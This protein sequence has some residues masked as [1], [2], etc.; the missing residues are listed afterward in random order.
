M[1]TPLVHG[2]SAD[3]LA[4]PGSGLA[5][6]VVDAHPVIQSTPFE[7]IAQIV[8]ADAEASSSVFRMPDLYN[9]YPEVVRSLDTTYVERGDVTLYYWDSVPRW[10]YE[11]FTWDQV[12]G[13]EPI[14]KTT[15]RIQQMELEKTAQEIWDLLKLYDVDACP[16]EVLPY[17]AA[18][19]G[20]P[21]PSAREESQR[22]F[23][24]ELAQTYRN[25][26]T[27]LSF[28]RLFESLGFE[29]TLQENYQRK[30]DGALVTGP[31]HALTSTDVVLSE[32][33]GTTTAST[34]PYSFQL[35]NTP[36]VRGSVKIKANSQSA[37]DPEIIIDD[38]EGGWPPGYTGVI[39]YV[40]G[41]GWITLAA[42]PT[43]V[44]QTI[45]VDYR[46]LVDPFPDPHGRRWTNLWRSSIVYVGLE[47]IDASVQLT[48]ELNNR[49]L[50]YL[51]LLKPAHV[52]V[53]ALEVIF[54]FED[55]ENANMDDDIG[56][57]ALAHVESPFATLYLGMGWAAENNGSLNPNPAYAGLIGRT[58]YEFPPPE[59][60]FDTVAAYTH[61]DTSRS[62]SYA[63]QV[64]PFTMNG[65]FTQPASGNNYEA[66]WFDTA[67][68][69]VFG[70]TV[71][72]D[73]AP[74]AGTISIAK[75]AGT[76]LG[77][78]DHIVINDGPAGGESTLISNF[79]DGGL[80][81]TVTML[82]VLPVAPDV[83]D[84]VTIID[85]GNANMRNLQA[86]YREQDPLDLDFGQY[87]LSGGNPP[88]G[89]LVGPFIT[90]IVASH[91]PV[92]GTSTLRFVRA[93]TTYEETAAG[94]GAF[95]NASTFLAAS[96]IDYVT[97]AV[98]VTFTVPPD[99]G[100]QVTVLSNIA[101]DKSLGEY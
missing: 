84:S 8:L 97:G 38:G 59:V 34:G 56:V 25:K 13:P 45:S 21:L 10:D 49:L 54:T 27:P 70:S 85:I 47:P 31:Q 60:T 58:G 23:L 86:S 20:T 71:T 66:D 43:L 42:A 40:T 1:S 37:Y 9:Y 67:A 46:R 94:T 55:S 100:T 4:L 26:G 75:G 76:A 52:I 87:L 89:I 29:L 18:L 63:P 92:L 44:G 77:I 101:A 51:D 39:D 62:P 19:L 15:T 53:E 80:F 73:V 5:W 41:A 98:T 32:A 28:F 99:A 83:G 69:T 36:V 6:M 95:T 91:R 30:D 48:E 33:I 90:T 79:V 65:R 81:Y 35:L 3:L 24:K 22:A 68:A 82:P 17:H 64:Y 50:L 57:H 74:A 93:G 78:G 88:D 12:L 2:D 7:V 96:N 11:P 61:P 16:K 14:L 72:A